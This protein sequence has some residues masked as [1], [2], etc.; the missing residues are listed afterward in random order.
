M[1]LKWTAY[2]L[3]RAALLNFSWSTKQLNF[4]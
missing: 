4:A 3:G 2:L 1:L